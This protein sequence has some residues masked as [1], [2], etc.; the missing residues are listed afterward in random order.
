MTVNDVEVVLKELVG[1]RERTEF[2]RI[3]C[4]RIDEIASN[5][6]DVP[7]HKL[8]AVLTRRRGDGD[9]FNRGA[10]DRRASES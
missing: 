7:V 8:P 10:F 1:H 9:Q 2:A 3:G 6:V 4:G 5:I